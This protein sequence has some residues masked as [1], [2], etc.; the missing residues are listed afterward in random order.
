MSHGRHVIAAVHHVPFRELLPPSHNAQWDFARAYLGS[1]R[2]GQLL[3]QHENVRTVVCGHSH[4][5]AEA[6]LDAARVSAI[7]IGSGY[8]V[9]KFRTIDVP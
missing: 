1:E 6:T 4:F 7:N 9:K 8:R 2:M 5:G 3:L